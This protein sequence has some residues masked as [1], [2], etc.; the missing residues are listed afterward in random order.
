MDEAAQTKAVIVDMSPSAFMDLKYEGDE[1]PEIGERIY[2]SR[3]AGDNV[4]GSD[5]VTYRLISE[6]EIKCFIDF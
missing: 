5:G 6:A 4:E 1:M 3:H 2:M